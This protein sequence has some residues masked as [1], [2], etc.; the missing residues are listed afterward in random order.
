MHTPDRHVE[1]HL[2]D[3]VV[4]LVRRAR[5]V[6]E[7]RLDRT[8][9][10]PQVVRRPQVEHP[11]LRDRGGHA[12]ARGRPHRQ[13]PS[14]GVAEGDHGGEVEPL[15]GELVDA[16][17]DVV[18]G[19]RGCRRRCRR[20]GTPGSRPPSPARPGWPRAAGPGS[21]RTPPS[22][23]RRGSPPRLRADRRPAGTARRTGWGRRRRRSV[24]GRLL[25]VRSREHPP[26][27]PP[28][29]HPASPTGCAEQGPTV[30]DSGS[31]PRRAQMAVSRGTALTTAFDLPAA[32]L[33]RDPPLLR[34]S[35]RLG[36]PAGWR[37]RCGG[38]AQHRGHPLA[39]GPAVGELGAV[40]AGRD[41]QHAVDQPRPEPRQ[42][43]LLEVRRHRGRRG[44]VEGQLD[45]AVGGVDAL[46]AGPR[47]AR[48]AF[49]QLCRPGW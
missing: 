3:R 14:G 30:H 16:G 40:L 9:A 33:V 19:R 28:A 29:P 47:R 24:P 31:W 4:A 18:E 23:S 36:G 6:P 2:R 49:A 39:R 22:R 34:A 8:T 17:S 11:G 26:R 37:R 46:P 7:Q 27:T 13:V 32:L 35:G 20:G 38:V 25:E 1:R 41:G 48:E 10:Q 21:R 45:P 44:Q 5:R 42:H 15:V 43:P 12:G